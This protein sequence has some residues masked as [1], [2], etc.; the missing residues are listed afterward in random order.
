VRMSVPYACAPAKCPRSL[1]EPLA[2][3]RF[4]GN[5]MGQHTVFEIRV[6][7]VGLDF[8]GKEQLLL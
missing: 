2:A 5:G 8:E 6:A 1:I 3:E 4:A 7:P